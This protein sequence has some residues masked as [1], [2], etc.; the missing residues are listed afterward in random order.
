[1]Q[2]EPCLQI[3]EDRLCLF[4]SQGHAVFSWCV[5]GLFFDSVEARDPFDC[6]F[7]DGK[8][9]TF[10]NINELAAH[11]NDAGLLAGAICPE[12]SMWFADLNGRPENL[13]MFSG[14]KW[15]S[16][17]NQVVT[18]G[19]DIA[20]IKSMLMYDTPRKDMPCLQPNE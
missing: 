15:V 16:A 4:L 2:R 20:C 19:L 11:M 7:G 17:V 13:M 10:L 12:Q 3:V 1:M 8:A 18:I 5:A 6:F 9:F 14:P